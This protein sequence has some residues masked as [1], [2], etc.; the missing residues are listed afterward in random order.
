MQ[1]CSFK[2]CPFIWVVLWL[3]FYPYV[4]RW[5]ELIIGFILMDGLF[6]GVLLI[7]SWALSPIF[8]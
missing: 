1:K 4:K 5:Q 6:N 7:Q 8:T 2:E 3:W